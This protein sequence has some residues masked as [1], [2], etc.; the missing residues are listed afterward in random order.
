MNFKNKRPK[1]RFK[2]TPLH[3]RRELRVMSYLKHRSHFWLTTLSLTAFIVGNMVG[4]HGWYVFWKSV[5]GAEDILYTGTVAPIEFVPDYQRWAEYGGDPH[6][7]TYRQVPANVLIPLPSYSADAKRNQTE[8][9]L[10]Q[11]VFSVGHLGAYDTGGDHDGS[12]P[13]IDIRVPVGT[14]VRSMANGIVADV[15]NDVGGYGQ[16]VVI[17]HPN[18]P[19]PDKPTK[20]TTLYSVYAHL[21][22]SYVTVGS[23][24]QKGERIALSGQTGFASGPHLHFQVD[25]DTAPWHPYW[26]FSGVEARLAGMSLTQAVN[27]GL[28][29]ERGDEYTVNPLLYV[30]ANYQATTL[31]VDASEHSSAPSERGG[32]RLLT[33]AEERAKARLAKRGVETKIVVMAEPQPVVEQEEQKE[34]VVEIQEVLAVPTLPEVSTPVDSVHIQ[35]DGS[36]AGRDWEKITVT[37]F[38]ADGNQIT[39]PTLPSGIYLRTAFGEAEFK[40]AQLSVANFENGEATVL[41]LP[42]GKRTVVVEVFPYRA[43]SKPMKYEAY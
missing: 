11:I 12:H 13:G 22:S 8:S 33:R 34:V 42:R 21:S 28:H 37:L 36:F 3:N 15:R 31:V 43:L 20:T 30:Q 24:V 10:S 16:L 27:A 23:L 35:N 29:Q 18:V 25:R 1:V 32:E 38:D 26:P 9:E 17:K 40:P 6:L 5:L 7:H 4:Q 14:P 41:M 39:N 19:D 2:H